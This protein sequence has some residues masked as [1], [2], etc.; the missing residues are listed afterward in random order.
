MTADKRWFLR[1]LNLVDGLTPEEVERMAQAFRMTSHAAKTHL[2]A[3]NGG[4]L[5]LKQGKVRLYRLTRDGRE[6]TTAVV[7]PGQLFGTGALAGAETNATRAEVIEDALVCTVE[8]SQLL[9]LMASSP[10]LMAR[11][12]MSMARQITVLED[13]VE[14]LGV[15][16]LPARLARLLLEIS[17][18]DDGSLTCDWSQD[19]LASALIT[20]RESVSRLLSDWRRKRIVEPARRHIVIRETG[21]LR[22]IS[23]RS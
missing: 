11:V 2:E 15:Q 18:P 4:V 7:S 8:P 12:V 9:R 16:S 13:R 3:A 22:S 23:D 17:V 20:S 14:E 5:L 1:R 6:A 10:A 19:E 21:K